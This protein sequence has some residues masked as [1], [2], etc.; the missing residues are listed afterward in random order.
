MPHADATIILVPGLLSDETVWTPILPLLQALAPVR[1][2]DNRTGNSLSEMAE[3]ALALTEGPLMVAGHSMGGRIAFEMVRMAPRRIKRLVVLDTGAAPLSPGEREGRDR[4]T[5][6][7]TH[8]GMAA[9]AAAWLPPMLAER[10]RQDPM[11]VNELVDM[12]QRMTPEIHRR[13]IAALIAR[14][15]AT[16][17]LGQIAC[18]TL[19]LVGENDE[20]SPPRDHAK[21]AEKLPD[22][23][24]KIIPGAGHFAPIEAPQAVGRAI[25]DWFTR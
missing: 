6:L 20:W 7:S 17:L 4:M 18:P 25:A 23:A 21:M 2:A 5:A 12:V 24:L 1:I 9:L 22:G 8:R 11:L 16:P 14:P 15:D 3:N 19:F 13:Q 10:N